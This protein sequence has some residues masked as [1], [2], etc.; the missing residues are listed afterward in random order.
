MRTFLI[1]AVVLGVLASIPIV[2]T[3]TV[4][5]AGGDIEITPIAHSSVQV[6]HAG[7]VVHVD[8]WSEG[9]YSS[10][11]AGQADLILVT[12]TPG[13]H[14]DLEAIRMLRKPG[15]PVVIPARGRD[16]LPD[17]TVMAI[18]ETKTLAGVTVEAIAMYDLIPGDPF[19]PKG[20]G[21]GYVVTLGGKRIYFAGVTE[22]TPEMQA[23]EDIEVA[24]LSMN[25]PHGRMTPS[26]AADCVRIFKPRVVYPYHYNEEQIVVAFRDALKDDPV[27]VRSGAWYPDAAR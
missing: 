25:L 26:A 24:F 23:L 12:D 27:E 4:P 20:R 7:T 3:D 5:A 8:P 16:Q 9:D 10:S 14:M 18:G 22:C 1:G 11:S 19:H 6:E 17:G 15:A 13:H 2:A 21:N